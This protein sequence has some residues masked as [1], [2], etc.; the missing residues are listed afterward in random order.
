[1]GRTLMRWV[2]GLCC[3]L[4]AP[5]VLQSARVAGQALVLLPANVRLSFEKAGQMSVE[6]SVK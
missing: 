6:A 2:T 3:A 4:A 5:A 1:M